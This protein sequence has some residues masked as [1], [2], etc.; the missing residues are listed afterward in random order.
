MSSLSEARLLSC[1]FSEDIWLSYLS[2]SSASEVS[3]TSFASDLTRANSSEWDARSCST[4]S[5]CEELAIAIISALIFST[6]AACFC[7][8]SSFVIF[9]CSEWDCIRLDFSSSKS[10]FS[11]PISADAFASMDFSFSSEVR[12]AASFSSFAA[13][14]CCSNDDRSD[15]NLFWMSSFSDVRVLSFSFKANISLSSDA[16]ISAKDASASD[17]TRSISA[18][19]DAI[20]WSICSDCEEL[21]ID[22]MSAFVFSSSW[23]CSSFNSAFTLSRSEIRRSSAVVCTFSS[24]AIESDWSSSLKHSSLDSCEPD[25]R[26]NSASRDLAAASSI[27]DLTRC[28][29]C[30]CDSEAALSSDRIRSISAEWADCSS[31]VS[32][33]RTFSISAWC[34]CCISI[35]FSSEDCPISAC[36]SLRTLSSSE[37]NFVASSSNANWAFDFISAIS[38]ECSSAIFRLSSW[39]DFSIVDRLDWCSAS[40]SARNSLIASI[41]AA[42]TRSASRSEFDSA[43]SSKARLIASSCSDWALDCK[44]STSRAYLSFSSVSFSFSSSACC[45]FKSSVTRSNSA[46]WRGLS[47]AKDASNSLIFSSFSFNTSA[48]T[49]S[50]NPSPTAANFSSITFTFSSAL[51]FSS[52]TFFNSSLNT[53]YCPIW[54]LNFSTNVCFSFLSD[55]TSSSFCLNRSSNSDIDPSPFSLGINPPSFLTFANASSISIFI[56]AISC[57]FSCVTL[58][59]T[60][61]ASAWAC[62]VMTLYSF[63]I[64][65]KFNWCRSSVFLQA[66]WIIDTS[67]TTAASVVPFFWA[68]CFICSLASS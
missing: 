12:A 31:V 59:L 8:N 49:C 64:C 36:I 27:S 14:T 25:T 62:I 26:L 43:C 46:A 21:A 54:V 30:W 9:I 63:C 16:F 57:S 50:E 3:A 4:C 29:S 18:L 42:M 56:L 24:S 38:A 33:S 5:D 28:N 47:W 11:L 55:N 51:A 68:N 22:S 34:A 6:S 2:R 53:L 58:F 66:D 48:D 32:S 19:W 65:C 37:A 52:L 10:A 13:C 17:W 1:S 35:N 44:S 40:N 45:F 61:S 7:A 41:F 67:S 15:A 23:A 60:F 39:C 20:S